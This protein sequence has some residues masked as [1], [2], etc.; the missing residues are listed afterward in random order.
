LVARVRGHCDAV[1]RSRACRGSRGVRHHRGGVR[2]AGIRRAPQRTHADPQGLRGTELEGAPNVGGCN[3]GRGDRRGRVVKPPLPAGE[4]GPS[5]TP[6]RLH[7]R[8]ETWEVLVGGRSLFDSEPLRGVWGERTSPPGRSGS[9]SWD[10]RERT[11]RVRSW[12]SRGPHQPIR[13][14]AWWPEG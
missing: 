2:R 3:E 14:M 8:G 13:T 11:A 9:R 6:S 10:T 5:L 1:R 12:A 7:G 4:D